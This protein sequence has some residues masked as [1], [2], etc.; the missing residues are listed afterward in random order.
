MQRT[1]DE[2]RVQ[3]GQNEVRKG[4]LERELVAAQES[5][6]RQGTG[7]A[8]ARPA[9]P[10]SARRR[11]A[12]EGAWRARGEGGG[13]RRDSRQHRRGAP[14]AAGRARLD[15]RQGRGPG[16]TLADASDKTMLAQR[17]L[18]ARDL[19]VEELLRSSKDLEARLGGTTGQ[20]DD[21][22]EQVRQLTEQIGTLSRQ[23][24][25][26]DQALDLKQSEIDAQGATIANLGERLNVALANKVE[27]LAQYRSE[28]FGALRRVLGERSDVRVVG[29]RF[30]FQSEVLFRAARP[31]SGRAAV[32][33]WPSS[34][35]RSRR[36]STKSRR[37]F[38]GCSRSTA[39]PTGADQQRTL[40]IELGAVDRARDRGRPV[41][42]DAGHPAGSPRCAWLRR[43]PAAR[44]RRSPEAYA[45]NRRIEIKL[46][47][48]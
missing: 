35:T 25:E 12:A 23:L 5:Q 44:P 21:A 37:T 43:V 42:F 34:R 24:A 32:T 3:A 41:P 47:T 7:R 40:P 39:T 8:S 31:T 2:M 17:E 26:L 22:V 11:G 1:L 29:D 48:R 13:A 15:P 38:P 18:A 30:V 46:T 28:F 4:E 33:S 19:R 27:E 6:D 14:P 20:R 9:G 36:S 16:D 45:R 10:A